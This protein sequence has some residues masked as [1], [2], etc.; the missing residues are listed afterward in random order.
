M[1][2][3][4]VYHNI[5]WSKYKGEVFSA[6]HQLAGATGEK[7]RFV[8]IAETE[9]ERAVLAPVDLRYHRYP[10]HLL[11]QGRYE[12]VSAL[13][14]SWALAG[15]LL[16]HPADVVILPGYHKPEYWAMLLTCMLTGRRRAVFCDSTAYD[17]PRGGWRT[18]AKR[19]FF[20]ACHGFFGYGSRSAEYL[21][22]HGAPVERIFERC[23]AA[24]LPI[25]FD[26]EAALQLRLRLRAHPAEPLF[27]YVGRLAPEKDLPTLLQALQRFRQMHGHGRLELVGDGPERAALQ[28]QA[29]ALGLDEAVRFRGALDLAEIGQAYAQ[30]TC[31]VLPSRSEP[32]GLVA[33]EALHHGCPILVSEA[34]GCRPELVV[35][36]VT[37]RAHAVGDVADLAAAMTA[38]AQD[39]RD[40]ASIA[41]SCQAHIA[42]FSPEQAAR[43][44]LKGC[45]RILAPA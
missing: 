2:R 15:D 3:I 8:Q 43:Q 21:R 10:F 42:H 19:L 32:W 27:L 9:G 35:P 14:R 29:K 11:F 41:R 33:N 18:V 45:A 37:G 6:L 20:R 28:A 1:S 17:R 36:G 4:T 5:M 25:G 26:R 12:A 39:S 23:Q 40:E 7:V 13:R 44:I 38:L 16:R 30:A 34:C 24:A 22:S 31:L